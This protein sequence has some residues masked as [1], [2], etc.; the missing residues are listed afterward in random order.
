MAILTAYEQFVMSGLDIRRIYQFLDTDVFN[1]NVIAGEFED[2]YHV[3]TTL[4]ERF[5]LFGNTFSV[6]GSGNMVNG[7]IEKW[8]QW[9]WDS[10]S[11]SWVEYFSFT[12]IDV[13]MS[14]FYD[15][16]QTDDAGV[17]DFVLIEAMLS[18]DDV[19]TLS[20]DDDTANGYGGNDT[21][22]GGAGADELYGDLGH[23]TLRGGTGNDN[24]YGGSGNDVLNG[25]GNADLLD[26]GTSADILRGS[27]GWDQLYGGS[28][29]DVLRG[30]AGNDGLRGGAGN[31]LLRGDS[32]KDWLRG[33]KGNDI[34][35][36]DQGQDT[37]AFI[38]GDDVDRIKDFDAIGGYHDVL[39]LSGLASVAGWNDLR[40]NHMSAR[41]N[42]VVIDGL[43]GDKIILEN[44]S[45]AS[46]DAGDFI[47]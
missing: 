23:D 43:N 39:D 35:F 9:N 3:T 10:G 28:G 13:A 37:F 38:T 2:E 17:D 42:D 30:G 11:S 25:G 46:L 45:L 24:L 21:I 33:G 16:G 31:D 47:F 18:G 8:T 44:V 5:S 1:D 15:A 20:A 7:N 14:D 26:G 34:L 27:Y 29:S 6:D 40:N 36:G 19:M 22:D 12:G 41:G 32:G 4:N